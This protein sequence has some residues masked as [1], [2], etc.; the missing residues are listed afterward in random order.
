[1]IKHRVRA[2]ALSHCLAHETVFPLLL[3][4]RAIHVNFSYGARDRWRNLPPPLMFLSFKLK[5]MTVQKSKRVVWSNKLVSYVLR[6]WSSKHWKNTARAVQ[7]VV[8][9]PVPSKGSTW[10]SKS[11]DQKV[12]TH[13]TVR[14]PDRLSGGDLTT[15]QGI[16]YLEVKLRMNL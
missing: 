11:C 8:I 10:Q 16:S 2:S 14:W 12:W 13:Q 7:V 15:E 9:F 3:P 1:M 4:E 5:N 6:D